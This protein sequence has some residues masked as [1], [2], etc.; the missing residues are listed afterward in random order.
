LDIS[1]ATSDTTETIEIGKIV[2]FETNVAYCGASKL[3]SY[4]D[5]GLATLTPN[6]DAVIKLETN[7]SERV[8]TTGVLTAKL[9]YVNGQTQ[10]Y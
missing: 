4:T 10:T 1:R 9:K 3:T 8:E 7:P 5:S 2:N 6:T